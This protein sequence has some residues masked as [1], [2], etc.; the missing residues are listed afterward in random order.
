MSRALENI[1]RGI[2]I[3]EISL[4]L[5]AVLKIWFTAKVFSLPPLF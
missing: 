1:F 2:R 4:A 3:K 5:V